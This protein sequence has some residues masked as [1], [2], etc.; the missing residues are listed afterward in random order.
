MFHDVAT[1]AGKYLNADNWVHA[2][3]TYGPIRNVGGGAYASLH[4]GKYDVDDTFRLEEYDSSLP[5]KGKGNW[6]PI[7]DLENIS[8]S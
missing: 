4:T 2:V 1:K 7:T 8:G 5:P 3:D 6:S